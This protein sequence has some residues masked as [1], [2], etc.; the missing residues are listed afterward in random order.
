MLN[1]QIQWFITMPGVSIRAVDT[2]AQRCVRYNLVNIGLMQKNTADDS[3]PTAVNDMSVVFRRLDHT[4]SSGK[5]LLLRLISKGGIINMIMLRSW[6]LTRNHKTLYVKNKPFFYQ[7]RFRCSESS[8]K[9]AGVLW[10]L[11]LHGHFSLRGSS[12][13]TL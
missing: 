11:S 4:S 6:V 1:K 3:V 13:Y 9:Y 12:V 5:L 8:C 7:L 10:K 2:D